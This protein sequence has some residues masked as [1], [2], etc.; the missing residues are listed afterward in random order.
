MRPAKSLRA[1]SARPRG[2]CAGGTRPGARGGG[3]RSTPARSSGGTQRLRSADAALLFLALPP[4]SPRTP[5][6]DSLTAAWRSPEQEPKP[7]PE[8]ESRRSPAAASEK[9]G[10]GAGEGR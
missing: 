1:G 3:T 9:E 6:P 7:E 8:P 10:A 5:I 2:V 4:R